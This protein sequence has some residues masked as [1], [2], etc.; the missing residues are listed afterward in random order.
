MKAKLIFIYFW[1]LIF[2]F[3]SLYVKAKHHIVYFWTPYWITNNFTE[4]WRQKII[5]II[6]L[7][8]RVH[9]YFTESMKKGRIIFYIFLDNSCPDNFNEWWRQNFFFNYIGCNKLSF[10]YF[11]THVSI[12]TL[13]NFEGKYLFIYIFF[14]YKNSSRLFWRYLPWY[15]RTAVS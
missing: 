12:I 2:G 5:L 13:L 14:I 7:D 15:K 11:R 1:L 9:N 10:I 3:I 8:R 6:F 4:W